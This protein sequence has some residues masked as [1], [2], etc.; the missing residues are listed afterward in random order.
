MIAGAPGGSPAGGRGAVRSPPRWLSL[1][2]DVP[3]FPQPGVTFKDISPLLADS[4]AFADVVWQLAA[5][6]RRDDGSA[7]V[8]KVAGVEARGFIFAAPVAMAL[9][10]GLV[11]VRKAGKLPGATYR[12]SYSLEYAES[13]LEIHTD[14]FSAGDRVLIVDDVLATGGTVEA[15]ASLVAAAGASVTAVAVLIELS[16]LGGRARLAGLPVQALTTV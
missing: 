2:R 14:A 13:T 6:A 9:D 4:A 5:V 11:P 3:D 8:D 12:Q 1:I 7:A 16:F 10:V 15:T